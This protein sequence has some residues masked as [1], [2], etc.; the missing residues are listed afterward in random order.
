MLEIKTDLLP[1]VELLRD[2]IGNVT[3]TIRN[4]EGEILASG[5][6][7]VFLYGVITAR[8]V[9]ANRALSDLGAL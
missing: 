2:D 9:A 6:A 5:T 3:C 4:A 1:R 8:Q 7:S